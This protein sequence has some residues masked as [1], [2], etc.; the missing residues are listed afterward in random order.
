MNFLGDIYDQH[1]RMMNIDAYGNEQKKTK[2]SHPYSYDEFVNWQDRKGLMEEVCKD[3]TGSCYTD[4]LLGWDWDKHN[5]L[6]EKHF[7]NKGQYWNDRD[8]E[9]IEAF[10]R[11]WTGKETL[12][13]IQVR[14]YCNISNGYPTW[15][16]VWEGTGE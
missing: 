14:E 16:L 9:K 12:K 2:S 8:P 5:E 4:R 11:D 3:A 15:L 7:G 13:L 1:Y 6:C 10:L